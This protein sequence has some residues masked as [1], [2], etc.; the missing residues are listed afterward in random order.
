M[1]RHSRLAA[2]NIG[3]HAF[4]GRIQM[5]NQYK[6]HAGIDWK[7]PEELSESIQASG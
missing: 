4:M 6:S 2:E 3:E 1:D 7:R 5:L